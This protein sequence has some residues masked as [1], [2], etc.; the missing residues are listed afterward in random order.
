[1][2]RRFTVYKNG[3]AVGVTATQ[4]YTETVLSAAISRKK[5]SFHSALQ[6]RNKIKLA[7]WLNIPVVGLCEKISCHLK[8]SLVSDLI[9]KP[10]KWMNG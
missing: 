1:M 6:S 7:Q 10:A 2:D 3:R 8:L 9:K 4:P 5:N